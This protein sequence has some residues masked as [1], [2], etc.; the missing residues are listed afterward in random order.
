[1]K[2]FYGI[3]L[4][5]LDNLDE[6][7]RTL[8]SLKDVEMEASLRA[9]VNEY[10]Q[11]IQKRRKFTRFGASLSLGY[12]FDTNRNAAPSSK[13]RLLGDSPLA[14]SGTSRQRRDTSVLLI[15]GLDVAHDLGFQAGHQL[16]GSFDYFLGEQ[17][18]IDDLDVESFAFDGGAVLKNALADLTMTGFWEH[19]LLSR[20]TFVRAAGFNTRLD[21]DLTKRLSLFVSN[22]WG[23][24]EFL[25]IT[26][27][28]AAPER[29]GNRDTFLTGADYQLTSTMRVSG[30]LGYER[31]G[32]KT[33][34]NAYDGFLL[35]GSHLWLPGEGQFVINAISYGFNSYDGP[36]RAISAVTRQDKQFRTRVTYGAPL[37]F[38]LGKWGDHWIFDDTTG[39]LSFEYFRSLSN[40]TN[41]TYRNFKSTMMLTKRVEF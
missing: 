14:V 21:R 22:R 25:D 2:L 5:R 26:E 39:T 40:I 24:E 32:A 20:E 38:F 8:E 36:D 11:E 41:Y 7:Q 18:A 4:F 10:L 12:Q 19:T 6:A 17:T 29:L 31:K 28:R 13:T 35:S 27:N 9:E 3:V 34:Y 30:S 37:T 33:D 15:Q 1:M 23:W 16:I